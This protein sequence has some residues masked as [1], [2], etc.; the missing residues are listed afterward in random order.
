MYCSKSISYHNLVNV[1]VIV[2]AFV[3]VE[4]LWKILTVKEHVHVIVIEA[5]V[6][7]AVVEIVVV[8][9]VVA[10]VVLSSGELYVEASISRSS[11]SNFAG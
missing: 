1:V 4:I 5:E 8:V 11:S 7:E 10:V 6:I 2:A 9:V 3:V